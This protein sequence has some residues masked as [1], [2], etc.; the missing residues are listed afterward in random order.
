MLMGIGVWSP[1]SASSDDLF[2]A[3]SV[4][5]LAN[6]ANIFTLYASFPFI[7]LVPLTG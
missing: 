7:V 2:N 3:R 1:C 4:M 6:M 5:A